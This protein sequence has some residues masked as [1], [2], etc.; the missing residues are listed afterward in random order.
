MRKLILLLK[1]FVKNV[2]QETKTVT[3]RLCFS[4]I[5]NK[6]LETRNENVSKDYDLS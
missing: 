3:K 1:M 4:K 6:K 2:G 5:K